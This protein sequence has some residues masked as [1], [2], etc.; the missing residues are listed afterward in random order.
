M[1]EN[2]RPH[3][4]KHR[5]LIILHVIAVIAIMIVDCASKRNHMEKTVRC[6]INDYSSAEQ[7]PSFCIFLISFKSPTVISCIQAKPPKMSSFLQVGF[8]MIFST[9][10]SSTMVVE[11]VPFLSQIVE[12]VV[13]PIYDL[14]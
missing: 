1:S 11:I 5:L 10:Y 8:I 9:Y 14:L 12:K 13:V 6:S 7:R 3:K 4:S 2:M